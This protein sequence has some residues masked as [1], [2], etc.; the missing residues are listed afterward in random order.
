MRLISVYCILLGQQVC[1]SDEEELEEIEFQPGLI[2][3]DLN[4]MV[5][6]K[7]V[8]GQPEQVAPLE[9]GPN[10]FAT[11]DFGQGPESTECTNLL[12]SAARDKAEHQEQQQ[13]KTKVKSKAK[14]NKKL[15]LL[16][17]RPAAARAEAPERSNS[18]QDFF[19][20]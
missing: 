5:A 1:S 8:P 4:Q 20:L 9:E 2:S 15:K 19:F 17:R 3:F 16:K 12:L 18:K 14:P 10:G 13:K 11:G 7:T 6:R